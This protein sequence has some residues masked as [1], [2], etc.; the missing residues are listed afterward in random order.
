MHGHGIKRI[1]A[2]LVVMASM[3]AVWVFT[4]RFMDSRAVFPEET[5]E[6]ETQ[7]EDIVYLE[8]QETETVPDE[9]DKPGRIKYGDFTVLEN[10]D[11]EAMAEM[12]S[13]H[14]DTKGRSRYLEADVTRDGAHEL[15][16][17]V[18]RNDMKT[19]VVIA[20]FAEQ[21][22]NWKRIL[23]DPETG[24]DF[25]L[26]GREGLVY[27]RKNEWAVSE[28][29][30]TEVL[31]DRGYE[32]YGGESLTMYLVADEDLYLNEVDAA[33]RKRLDD[34]TGRGVWYYMLKTGQPQ[35]D[36]EKVSSGEW[37]S[38]FAR[39]CG[40]PFA[41]VAPDIET[42]RTGTET[43][44]AKNMFLARRSREGAPAYEEALYY[45][46]ITTGDRRDAINN[47]LRK[48]AFAELLGDEEGREAADDPDT[49]FDRI[50][51]D[52]KISRTSVMDYGVVTD[53]DALLSVLFSS[54]R[55]ENGEATEQLSF[56]TIDKKA[57]RQVQLGDLTSVDKITEAIRN[58]YGEVFF[59]DT[60]DFSYTHDEDKT[61]DAGW[62]LSAFEQTRTRTDAWKKVGLDEQYLL[63]AINTGEE[64]NTEAVLR[65]PRWGIGLSGGG[66]MALF[67][68]HPLYPVLRET[69][70]MA[71]SLVVRKQPDGFLV[72]Y[73]TKDGGRIRMDIYASDE[74]LPENA[75]P[76]E[77][78]DYYA[79]KY[80]NMTAFAA[81][82]CTV[83]GGK[84][85]RFFAIEQDYGAQGHTFL[86]T[87]DDVYVIESRASS[88]RELF[89]VNGSAPGKTLSVSSYCSLHDDGVHDV[90][91]HNY[92]TGG[93]RLSH[94][95]SD[96]L[97]FDYTLYPA[98]DEA[99]G[100]SQIGI[101]MREGEGGVHF[102]TGTRSAVYTFRDVN[103]DG[104]DDLTF[105]EIGE[106][107]HGGERNFI[108]HE[109]L[110]E[111]VEG[112]EELE[113]KAAYRFEPE[114][115]YCLIGEGTDRVTL[116]AFD[117]AGAFVPL[118]R[119]ETKGGTSS[120]RAR[121]ILNEN[122]EERVIVD[123]EADAQ[124][125]QTLVTSVFLWQGLV[126]TDP[127]EEKE[128]DLLRVV[129]TKKRASD[130]IDPYDVYRLFVMDDSGKLYG[131]LE[132]ERLGGLLR[133]ITAEEVLRDGIMTRDSE[134]CLWYGEEEEVLRIPVKNLLE[135]AGYE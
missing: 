6:E 30:C 14:A 53:T 19:E 102:D 127:D 22:G 125:M 13:V 86:Q 115:G 57:G 69:F 24:N 63:F 33:M 8:Q 113:G 34:I 31:F 132:A 78:R 10:T 40:A 5:A 70:D 64:Q 52:E 17:L 76:E 3:A 80:E 55:E 37:M 79:R 114:T 59:V 108:F 26:A 23:W 131:Y 72:S 134:I 130:I 4:N 29:H 97:W 47:L 94:E 51:A 62:I 61:H 36:A 109:G 120:A 128:G 110:R 71:Q 121:M 54:L 56:L 60:T 91:W 7:A 48:G 111:Y 112:P 129:V 21:G 28:V 65:I 85:Y 9:N 118:R 99:D 58:G 119:L 49:Y 135:E 46:Q 12:E 87:G 126:D 50:V 35:E 117:E 116:Y 133:D 89:L 101:A 75:S 122:E 15:L 93:M 104:Y 74:T 106:T 41:H 92:D 84:S 18:A 100:F 107:D 42:I 96:G 39:M 105:G 43:G 124:A 123:G 66:H 73:A 88:T 83:T 45:P 20:V 2:C 67:K 27:V 82:T 81:G 44:I 103:D 68:R 98:E 38:R 77:E 32:L 16:W 11:A 25:Y 1:L 90:V 95:I